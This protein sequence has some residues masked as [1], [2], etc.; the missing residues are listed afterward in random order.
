MVP[1]YIISSSLVVFAN[2]KTRLPSNEY[3][4]TLVSDLCARHKKN[5]RLSIVLNRR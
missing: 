5:L 2:A 4:G 3:A 1:A